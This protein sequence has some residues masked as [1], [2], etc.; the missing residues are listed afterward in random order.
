KEDHNAN[1]MTA[2]RHAWQVAQNAAH[3]LA[4]ELTCAARA[5]DLRLRQMPTAHP[6]KGVAKAHRRIRSA[7]PFI[8]GDALWGPEVEKLKKMLVTGEF[9]G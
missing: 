5:L 1:A 8:E 6:G 9:E 4:I 2:A 7:I 3:V